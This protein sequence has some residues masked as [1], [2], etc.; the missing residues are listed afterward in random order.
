MVDEGMI[1]RGRER[2]REVKKKK[3]C[4]GMESYEKCDVKDH[5]VG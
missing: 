2:Q 3:M 1:G 5:T 4:E